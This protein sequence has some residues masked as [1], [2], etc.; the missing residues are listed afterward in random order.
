MSKPASDTPLPEVPYGP[1]VERTVPPRW[2]INKKDAATIAVRVA[3][4]FV[5][6]AIVKALAKK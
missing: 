4:P 3:A 6:G 1:P 5:I 2:K